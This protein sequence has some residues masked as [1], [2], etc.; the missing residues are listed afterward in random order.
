MKGCVHDPFDPQSDIGVHGETFRGGLGGGGWPDCSSRRAS[1]DEHKTGNENHMWLNWSWA[2]LRFANRRHKHPN[3]FV[4]RHK[5]IKLFLLSP[6]FSWW[7]AVAS[8]TLVCGKKKEKIIVGPQLPFWKS[9]W[10]N[11]V[12]FCC[13]LHFLSLCCPVCPN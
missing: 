7:A 1:S 8:A 12:F 6:P 5:T 3:H 4:C 2:L 13:A 9:V 11:I 10:G